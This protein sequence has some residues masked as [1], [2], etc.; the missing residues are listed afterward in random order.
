MDAALYRQMAETQTTHWWF[1]A[2]RD[3][4]RATLNG[5]RWRAN[6]RIL[7]VGCG[8]G[9]NL[10]MLSSL[11]P[12]WA[13]ERNDYAIKVARSTAAVDVR[14]GWLPDRI[15]FD[16]DEQ[17]DLV[18]LFDVLEHVEDDVAA[19]RALAPL[20]T[21]GGKVAIAVPAYPWLFGPHDRALHHFRRYTARALGRKAE[22]AG[23]RVLRAGYFNTLLFPL[24]LAARLLAQWGM[25]SGAD[26]ARMPGSITNRVLHRIFAL[27]RHVVAHVGFPF[28]SSV[29]VVIE[30][31]E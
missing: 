7:E 14:K 30:R 31:R 5:L 22:A 13:M 21:A 20:I 24:I 4:L 11:G 15:P 6:P 17:F 16:P 10:R 8:T 19:L 2:R 1:V 26:D 29:L 3:I 18:C 23:F 12:V 9:A 25:V 28:G 27:E